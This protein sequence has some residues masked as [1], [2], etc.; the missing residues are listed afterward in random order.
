VIEQVARE[1]GISEPTLRRA[2][3]ALEVQSVRLR[4]EWLWSLP[5]ASDRAID[6]AS[7]RFQEQS[8]AWFVA[9]PRGDA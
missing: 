3:Q 8:H 7:K 1:H 5:P 6:E 2:K 4:D 9:H